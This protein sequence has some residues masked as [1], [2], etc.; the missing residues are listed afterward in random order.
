[1][2]KI[3]Q[4][5]SEGLNNK[6]DLKIEVL[7]CNNK[8][9]TEKETINGVKITKSSNLKNL[10]GMPIS[11]SFFKLFKKI[12]KEV[13]IVDLH[14]PFPLGDIAIFLFR[15]KAK[16]IVHYHSDIVRQK[17]LA[18]FLKPILNNTLRLAS[19]IIISNPRLL[20]NSPYL[21][22][23]TKKCVV[24]PFGVD[25][26][27]FQKFDKSKVNS[28]K[29][30]YGDFALFVGRTSYYKGL[31]YLIDA[32]KNI[33]Q[34]LVIVGEGKNKKILKK[35]VESLKLDNRVY[36]LAPLPESDLI[37][38]Y[39]ACSVFVLPSI[40]KSEAFGIVLIEAM[41]CGKP[42]ISTE[43]GTGTSFVNQNDI[44]G[45]VVPPKDAKSLTE[46]INKLLKDKKMAEIF[47]H[48][49]RTRIENIFT[50]DKM[51]KSTQWVYLSL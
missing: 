37:N 26:N 44:T 29:Q 40:F 48:S 46:A 5:I 19:K 50:L 4:Q 20:E 12:I 28:I 9:K 32:M 34:K 18:F 7:C 15:P 17:L 49:A 31:D 11:F 6:D 45:F 22:K 21:Q 8:N 51:L 38:F 41:A 39:N 24:V 1:M 2:E 13:D 3:V 47:G 25:I 43:L 14:V 10:W 42:I 35:K 33:S 27:K 16:L 23:F 30:K 36:F